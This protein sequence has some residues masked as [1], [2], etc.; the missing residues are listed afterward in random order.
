MLTS[1]KNKLEEKANKL[2]QLEQQQEYDNNTNNQSYYSY[3]QSHYESYQS[4]SNERTHQEPYIQDHDEYDYEFENQENWLDQ[5]QSRCEDGLEHE[6]VDNSNE[7]MTF[8]E[9][10]QTEGEY[11]QESKATSH[12]ILGDKYIKSSVSE[13]SDIM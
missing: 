7:V 2:R 12:Q 5:T 4:P 1:Y 6:Y 8:E 9:I 3:S 13:L 11:D 10:Y